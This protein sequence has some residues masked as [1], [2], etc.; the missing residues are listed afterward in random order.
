MK[1]KR[2]ATAMLLWLAIYSVCAHV[3]S[4][5]KALPVPQFYRML[6]RLNYNRW[7]YDQLN[8]SITII[9]DRQK[10]CDFFVRRAQENHRLFAES[11]ATIDSILTYFAQPDSLIPDTVYQNYYQAFYSTIGATSN[12]D[13]FQDDELLAPLRDRY[14]RHVVPDSVNYLMHLIIKQAG[15]EYGIHNILPGDTTHLRRSF[16]YLYRLYD[17][18]DTTNAKNRIYYRQALV[19]LCLPSVWLRGK[20]FTYEQQV[21]VWRKLK[22]LISDK[23]I[24]PDSLNGKGVYSMAIQ[25]CRNFEESLVRNVYFNDRKAVP[26]ALADSVMHATLARTD[27]AK[28]STLNRLRYVLMH[29]YLGDI[30]A[31]EGYKQSWRICEE[32]RKAIG[33]KMLT[34]AQFRPLLSNYFTPIYFNDVAHFSKQRKHHNTKQIAKAVSQTAMKRTNKQYMNL[35]VQILRNFTL[36]SRLLRHLTP[37]E[38]IR[39]M[40]QITVSSQVTTYAHSV[41]VAKLATTL[42]DGILKHSPQLLTG[43][44]GH[45]TAKAVKRHARQYRDFIYHAALYH[46]VGKNTLPTVVSNDFRPLTDE[47]FGIIK[48]HP[49]LGLD[50]LAISPTL[51]KYHDTTLGHHKWYNGKGGYPESF[52]NTKSPVRILIDIVTLCDCMQAATE[53]L[54][55]NYKQEKTFDVLMEEMRQGAGTRYNPDLVALIDGHPELA[56]K[57]EV[58]VTS[59]WLDIY[60]NIYHDYFQG[61]KAS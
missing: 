36:H 3:L 55:R 12:S 44:L 45:T 34:D 18:P 9:C 57:L 53:R 2:I 29:Y 19:E 4:Q 32:E 35:Y 17:H 27:L 48:L 24:T 37:Q 60:Y 50:F 31:E 14:E 52:D 5:D 49:E 40:G 23:R 16:N 46:D 59:G 21:E 25:R 7:Y 15:K 47:E 26:K 39:F 61:N 1:T 20:M 41:H 28:A 54:G 38:R 58:L 56:R 11:K 43:T 42:M 13:S 6:D 51:T 22:A 30:T 8:D 10:W 33:N